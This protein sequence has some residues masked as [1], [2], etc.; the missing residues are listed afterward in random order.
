LAGGNYDFDGGPE[1]LPKKDTSGYGQIEERAQR[2]F[3]FAAQSK[4]REA[5]IAQ[6]QMQEKKNEGGEHV[7]RVKSEGANQRADQVFQNKRTLQGEAEQAKAERL[8]KSLENKRTIAGQ[9]EAGKNTRAI[10]GNKTRLQTNYESNHPSAKPADIKKYVESMG[11][12][13][14]PGA[15]QGQ[16]GQRPQGGQQQGQQPKFNLQSSDMGKLRSMAENG[17]ITADV[18]A[19]WEKTYGPGSLDI[20]LSQLGL[21]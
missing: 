12:E 20:A 6:M 21:R 5:Y 4:Q 9:A 15:P 13:Y 1:T 7:Q 17:Q 8:D 18:R 11:E 2:I 3:P 14:V 19:R 10:Q 16:G